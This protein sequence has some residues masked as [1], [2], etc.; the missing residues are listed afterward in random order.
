MIII[1]DNDNDNDNNNNLIEIDVKE[2]K[3]ILHKKKN[4]KKFKII[5]NNQSNVY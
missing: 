2:L 5:D 3:K 4:K 1:I